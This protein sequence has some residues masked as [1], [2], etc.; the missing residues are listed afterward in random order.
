MN[1]SK[2]LNVKYCN[3]KSVMQSVVS[4]LYIR[5]EPVVIE[6]NVEIYEVVKR[7]KSITDSIP[8]SAAFFILNY[9]KLHVL[10]VK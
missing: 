2:H 8:I 10:K 9:A 3:S 5:H 7:K 4:P 6:D 1:L